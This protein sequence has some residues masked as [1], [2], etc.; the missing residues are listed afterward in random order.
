M[1]RSSS[2][3]IAA[4]VAALRA[5]TCPTNRAARPQDQPR[6]VRFITISR[7]AGT[8]GRSL[9]KSLVERLNAS[10]AGELAWTVW[11]SELVDR[12][13]AEYHLPPATVAALEDER[14]NWLEEALAG[15]TI[16]TLGERQVFHRVATTIRALAE[17]GRVVIVGRGAVLITKDLPGGLHLRLVAPLDQRIAST[18]VAR[19][20]SGTAAS[21][22][23]TE[24]DRSR[25]DFY[26]RY[27]PH[28]SLAPE[29][30]TATFNTGAIAREQIVEC[31]LS[32]MGIDHCASRREQIETTEG[33]CSHASS[34]ATN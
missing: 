21:E 9:A 6:V 18:A 19:H 28:D 23:V 20:M 4:M 33:R 3:Q 1:E 10:V 26:R 7:Q 12:I 15:L 14:P 22:W 34:S 2:A 31:V 5:G 8:G 27:W 30:F 32:L 16:T 25:A 13:A 11:D 24:R 29:D 17:V